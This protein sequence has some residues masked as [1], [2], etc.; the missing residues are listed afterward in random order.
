VHLANAAGWYVDNNHIYGA[1]GTA[2]YAS[3]LFGTSI[4]NNYIED[5]GD[6]GG[7]TTW[8]GI[9]GT[10][11]GDAASTIA[12]NRVFMFSTEHA[13]TSYTFIALTQVNYKGTG[14]VTVTG[15]DIRGSGS[16]ADTGFYFNAGSGS[17]LALSVTSSGN[18][19]SSVRTPRA[20][21]TG[22][23]ISAGM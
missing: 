8:Y 10:V 17:G 14:N 20:T 22:V 21:G 5:F 3:R 7:A 4:Q 11:Q 9:N 15:N 19:V 1:G 6:A 16:A 2:I 13:G 18:S 12:G 23:T